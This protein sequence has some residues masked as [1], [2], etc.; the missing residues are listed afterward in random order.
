MADSDDLRLNEL[1]RYR[2]T[3]S[4]LALEVHSHC[5]VPAGCGGAVLRWRKPDADLGITLS[6]YLGVAS[7]GFFLDGKPIQEQRTLVSP[8]EH[9]LSFVVDEPGKQGFLLM[10][11]SLRPHIAS[12]K[13]SQVTSRADGRWRAATR[14]PPE[15]WQLPG[16]DDS[17]FVPLV[18][19]PVSEPKG[20]DRWLW[21]MM[22]RNA[23]GLGLPSP[24]PRAWVRWT[25]RLD[26]E[27]F[28]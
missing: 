8:G 26:V 12:A 20:S 14:Q 18:E 22:Q 4:R 3:S 15:G 7:E 6:S 9:V 10:E 1:Q 24:A 11:I 5:E 27:G 13:Q 28:S 2:K 21:G 16:F 17:S 19:K 25:F 23:K